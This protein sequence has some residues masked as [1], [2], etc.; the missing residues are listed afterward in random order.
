MKLMRVSLILLNNV[1]KRIY[2]LEKIS[3][4]NLALLLF[5]SIKKDREAIIFPRVWE[6]LERAVV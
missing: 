6:V 1:I 3:L 2:L 4:N 5:L